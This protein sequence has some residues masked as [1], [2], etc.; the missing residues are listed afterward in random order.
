MNKQKKRVRGPTN[1]TIDFKVD[2]ILAWSRYER[3][4]RDIEQQD[5]IAISLLSRWKAELIRQ[6]YLLV[7][8]DGQL[9]KSN[10][11]GHS[12]APQLAAVPSQP[13][14]PAHSNQLMTEISQL[15]DKLL[16]QMMLNADLQTR[17]KE[18]EG[19]LAQAQTPVINRRKN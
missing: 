15:K 7:G 14:S 9:R 16:Q 1:Y 13:V 18:L 19:L 3:T 5:G 12:A 6:G 2:L 17:I 11:H 4:A 8:P 10:E